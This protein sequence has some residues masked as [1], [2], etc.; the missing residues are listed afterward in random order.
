MSPALSRRYSSSI[1][2]KAWMYF[3]D[4]V[5]KHVS[6]FRPVVS[7]WRI[8]SEIRAWSSRTSRC[9]SKIR[10]S[11]LPRLFSTSSWILAICWRVTRSALS[12]RATSSI[13]L[14]GSTW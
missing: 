12:N 3:L 4:T 1:S 8:V 7:N 6:M 10:A 11:F 13:C 9:A 2:E 14:S 5:S